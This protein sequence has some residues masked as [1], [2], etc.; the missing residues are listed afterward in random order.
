[1]SIERDLRS[2]FKYTA[3][4]LIQGNVIDGYIKNR[5][6]FAYAKNDNL[7]IFE[8][9]QANKHFI[10]P[11]ASKNIFVVENKDL[12]AKIEMGMIEFNTFDCILL[13]PE[14]FKF[15]KN[16]RIGRGLYLILE[17]QDFNFKTTG[18]YDEVKRIN[19]GYTFAVICKLK[20]G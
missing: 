5:N 7:I 17:H 9:F 10:I 19:L 2:F 20:R 15:I 8:A 13:T 14:V 11:D 6:L 12:E 3:S 4:D 1:M 16:L 18:S